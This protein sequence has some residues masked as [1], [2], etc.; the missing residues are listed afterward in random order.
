LSVS[1]RATGLATPSVIRLSENI[2]FT[3]VP[4]WTISDS[5]NSYKVSSSPF[6]IILPDVCPE[7]IFIC[8][9]NW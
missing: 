8:G 6:M 1:S 5:V 7:A 4:A 9:L 3:G 2:P